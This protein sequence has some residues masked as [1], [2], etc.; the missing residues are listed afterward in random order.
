MCIT[1]PQWVKYSNKHILNEL[2]CGRSHLFILMFMTTTLSWCFTFH[3][4]TCTSWYNGCQNL[5]HKHAHHLWPSNPLGSSVGPPASQSLI[6]KCHQ[7]EIPVCGYSHCQPL[8]YSHHELPLPRVVSVLPLHCLKIQISV[9]YCNLDLIWRCS[10][11][12]YLTRLHCH[13][14]Q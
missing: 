5:P 8:R 13:H 11:S 14:S 1:W 7:A 10:H 4:C 2:I 3:P 6:Q 12:C 9:W